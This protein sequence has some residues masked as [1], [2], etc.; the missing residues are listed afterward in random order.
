MIR[1]QCRK[2][3]ET[4]IEHPI[5]F[6]PRPL[7]DQR[8]KVLALGSCFALRVKEWLQSNGYGVLNE[9][10]LG[11]YDIRGRREFDPRIYYNTFC[12]RYEFERAAGQ[13]VQ[14]EDDIWEPHQNSLRVYQDPYRRMLAAEDRDVL[15]QRIR[16]VDDRMRRHILEADCVII[17]LGLTEV[18]FQQHN[19]NAICAAPG[20]SGGGGIGCEFRCT[21]YPE[22]FAN[23]QRVVEILHE[24]NPKA[25]LIV[26][27]SPVP[28]AA[29]WGGVDHC[30]ANTESK[31]TLRAVAGALVRKYE[32]V[33]YFHSYELV[34]QAQLHEVF[35][36]DGRH[37]LPEYVAGIMGDFERA[38]VRGA[39]TKIGSG[40]AGNSTV[41]KPR[42]PHF[43]DMSHLA[44]G[45]RH[46]H[47]LARSSDK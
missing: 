20:Y 32:Y 23:M 45:T 24:L 21:E 22:N 9:G 16:E 8:S 47:A 35:K 46:D 44:S 10:D 4:L 14:G 41:P 5:T 1:R 33:H 36:E 31:S 29:T 6:E 19:G 11:P 38:F 39:A 13:F 37:V 12:I 43:I 42:G 25:Q 34:M 40:T 18:F 2:I 17:T 26:T 15:W 30:I 3:S 7:I 27:V 28:L